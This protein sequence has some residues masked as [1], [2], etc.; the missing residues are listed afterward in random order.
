MIVMAEQEYREWLA[1]KAEAKEKAEPLW[2]KGKELAE[3]SG[4]IACHSID[5]SPK[6]GPTWKGL[7]GR[8]TTFTDGTTATA[9]EQYIRDYILTPNVKVIKGFPPAMPSFKGQLSD[10]DITAIIAYIKTLK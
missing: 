9:D 6:V 5:G 1:G 4:C 3:K 10:D 8:T 7:F 2:E